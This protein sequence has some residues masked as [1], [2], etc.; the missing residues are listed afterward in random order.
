[1]RIK[2]TKMAKAAG[3]L[4]ATALTLSCWMD[5]TW[6]WSDCGGAGETPE[7]KE[8]RE[9][10]EKY[11]LNLPPC[12]DGTV[13]IGNQVWQ[14]CN[15]NVE[16]SN[17]ISSCNNDNANCQRFGRLYDWAAANAVCPKG[18]HLPSKADWDELVATV[19]G[20]ETAGKYL[21]TSGWGGLDSYGFSAL[22]GG[23][24]SLGGYF[25]SDGSFSLVGYHGYWWSASDS[26]GRYY[27][28]YMDYNYE[29][30][31]DGYNKSYYLYSVRCLQ[32]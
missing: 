10:R 5:G 15:L 4:L 32:D 8:A 29:Y 26:S 9:E 18:W 11:V 21:K 1:M 22:P 2:L 7:E 13:K 12:V 24:G 25:S 20:K 14:K 28:R 16:P 17:G 27:Y 3:L 31:N 19:G 6:C 23:E 30:V